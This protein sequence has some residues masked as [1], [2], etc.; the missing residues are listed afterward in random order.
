M[1]SHPVKAWYPGRALGSPG[2]VASRMAAIFDM[3]MYRWWFPIPQS[4]MIVTMALTSGRCRPIAPSRITNT[5]VS[6][7]LTMMWLAVMLATWKAMRVSASSWS[8]WRCAGFE[9]DI[10]GLVHQ[11]YTGNTRHHRKQLL[12]S[13]CRYSS[14]GL[15]SILGGEI[16][17]VHF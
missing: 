17:Q 16:S 1:K 8:P 9:T 10:V 11:G 6:D 13:P 14:N 15:S 5:S 3:L 7:A 12:F 4:M 2:L